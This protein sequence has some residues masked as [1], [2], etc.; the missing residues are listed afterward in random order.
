MLQLCDFVAGRSEYTPNNRVYKTAPELLRSG[1]VLLY[2][3]QSLGKITKT[4]PMIARP[5]TATISTMLS[6]VK[7]IFPNNSINTAITIAQKLLN[8]KDF[9]YF[10]GFNSVFLNEDTQ[11]M[12]ECAKAA[13]HYAEKH[14]GNLR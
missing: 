7:S 10:Y 13:L 5:S 1:A 9:E 4:K 14:W 12:N 2:K 11:N 6:I 8:E 3:L